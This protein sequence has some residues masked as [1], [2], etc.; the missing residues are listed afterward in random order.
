M[1][2]LPTSPESTTAP[3]SWRLAHQTL[4]AITRRRAALDTNEARWLLVARTALAHVQLGYA[5]F[6]DY[7]VAEVGYSRR[8]AHERVRVAE[9]LETLPGTHAAVASGTLPF[10]AARELTRVVTPATEPRWLEAAEGKPLREIERL[11]AGRKRGDLPDDPPTPVVRNPILR[12]QISPATRALVRE[13]REQLAAERG[14]PLSDD[15]FLEALC[16]AV[17]RGGDAAAASPR[18]TSEVVERSDHAR[19]G[20]S[21]GADEAQAERRSSDASGDCSRSFGDE[22]L[23]TADTAGDTAPPPP[24]S[25]S[26]AAATRSGSR[27]ADGSDG[28]ATAR[29]RRRRPS[30]RPASSDAETAREPPPTCD[31]VAPATAA[32]ADSHPRGRRASP[33]VA[34]PLTPPENI[35]ELARAALRRLGASRRAARASVERARTHVGRDAS[36]A[37]LIDASLVVA[38]RGGGRDSAR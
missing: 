2:N 35:D 18:T 22:R 29:R 24:T 33:A 37:D 20:A 11:V 34:D 4:L 28:H 30:P 7:L 36:L 31:V 6:I 1:T 19:R 3:P 23:A 15:A 13:A 9:R 10:T 26:A 5:S 27:D 12:L 38:R 32:V 16:T 14:G 17:L 25:A 21:T 8:A